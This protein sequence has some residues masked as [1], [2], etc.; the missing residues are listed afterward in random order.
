[1]SN[2]RITDFHWMVVNAPSVNRSANCSPVRTCRMKLALSR[3]IRQIT[4][5]SEQGGCVTR[6]S[7][8]TAALNDDT[9]DCFV[10]LDSEQP[11]WA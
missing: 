8:G 2:N 6:V 1:M 11:G 10:V 9:N 3:L 5:P 7:I 4:S